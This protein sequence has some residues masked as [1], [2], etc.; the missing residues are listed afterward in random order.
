[1]NTITKINVL[2]LISGIFGGAA[3]AGPMI[4]FNDN[5][6]WC[7]YQDERVIIHDGKLIIGSVADSS[8][9]GGSARSGN[10]EVVTYDIDAGG[11]A[12]RTVLNANLEDDDHNTAAF[13]PLPDNRLLAMYS[14]HSSDRII[15]YRITTNPHD[16][17]SWQPEVQMTRNA[18]VTYS[19]VYRL[20]AE[21]NGNGR[22]YNFYRGENFNPNFIVSNDNGQTWSSNTWLIRKDG[23]R[24]YPRYTSNNVDRIHFITTEAHPRDYSNS[25][26]YGCLYNGRIY[27]ADGT[28]LHDLSTGPVAP[29]SL[30]KLYQGGVNNVAW[31]TGIRLDSNGYPYIAFSVQMDQNMNDL[32]YG[33]AR[34]DGSVWHVN[35]MAYA[36]SALYGAEADYSG[37]VALDPHNPNVVYISADVHPL[38][39]QPLI[40]TADNKRHYEL[41]RGTTSDLGA[42]WQ[43]EWITK[44]STVDNLRPIVP[45]WDG[46]TVLLWLRGTYWTYTNYDLDVVG[47]F[48]PEAIVSNEPLI[49]VQPESVTVRQGREATLTVAAQS[50]LPMSYQWYKVVEGGSDV[51]VGDDTATLTLAGVQTADEGTYYCV[52]TNSAGTALSLNANVSL[53][54]LLMHLPLD[55]TYADVTGNGYNAS[56]VGNPVFAGGKYNQALNVDGN[57]HLSVQNGETL[58]LSSGG[59]VSAWVKTSQLPTAW[60]TLAGKGRYAWR[61]CQNNNFGTAAFHFNSASNEFQA[62]GTMAIT[63]NTWRMITGTYDGRTLSLYIDG[64][65]DSSVPMTEPARVTADPVYIANRSDASRYWLGLVDDVRIYDYAL[66]S[67]TIKSLYHGHACY[68]VSRFDLNGDCVVDIA[69]MTLFMDQWLKDGF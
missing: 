50:P 12:V 9:T 4:V 41:F 8:G 14:R 61:L 18:N 69:D 65:L 37:L 52:V 67:A 34:W 5:G 7:W 23:H 58:H 60:A 43:W 32:R 21:N 39:G 3:L 40:S 36:G 59:T 64:Q 55:G 27:T 56:P 38:T 6:A 20:S 51:E 42:T 53:M 62:N 24:P 10:I 54:E 35:E 25:L 45:Q 63:D 57:D 33:Y 48:D 2:I 26:Y 13:L 49:T 19:N 16:T 44:N 68:E 29:E 46:R 15:R 22:I 28:L 47:V 66:D 30:T 1:M 17:T 31:T 11:P